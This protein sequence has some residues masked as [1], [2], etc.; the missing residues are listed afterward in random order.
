MQD[1]TRTW[2]DLVLPAEPASVRQARESVGEVLEAAGFGD[3]VFDAELAVSELVTNA[4]L[5]G[6][7]PITVS[8]AITPGGFRVRVH[9]GS[10]VSPAF[11]ML[12]PTAVT[13]RGLVLVSAVSD[14]WGV[15]PEEDGKTV[16]FGFDHDHPTPAEAEET[17][18]LLAAW[19][20][21]LVEDP[22][23]EKVRVV[24]TDV[25]AEQLAASES[26]TEGLFRELALVSEDSDQHERAQAIIRATAPLDALRLDIRHQAAVAVHAGH[27]TLDVTLTI[28]RED[29]EQV[30]DFM[31]GL[32]EAERLARH[33][34]LLVTP[35]TPGIT[36]FRRAFLRRLLDQLRS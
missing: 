15:D 26:H 20:D 33:G 19:A 25:P 30:R 9:D 4:V 17:D 5:H 27:A 34:D 6:R 35:G 16:W 28:R 21:G 3:R 10:P 24:L 31:H 22:A 23:R 8:F 2:R 13:G 7:E 1:N 14:S 18:R 12:D 29:A 32:D 11:S 36:A